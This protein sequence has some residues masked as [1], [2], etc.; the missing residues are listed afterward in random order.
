MSSLRELG[1]RIP[2][3]NVR[4]EFTRWLHWSERG[5]HLLSE[6]PRDLLH[7]Y[8]GVYLLAHF[9]RVPKGD[10]DP[11]DRRIVYVGEGGALG[12]RWYNFERSIAEHPGHSGGHAYRARY[13]RRL[14]TLHVAAF[15]IWLT[16]LEPKGNPA[17]PRSLTCRLRHH[18]E[19]G[20]LW[21]LYY[22]TA[23]CELLNRK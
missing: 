15:P 20:V 9:D 2:K 12:R 19:Q 21:H 14:E 6:D 23:G 11:T 3:D 22:T 7:G 1:F 17:D 10:A 5:D 8:S 13:K 16:E 4:K 18:V